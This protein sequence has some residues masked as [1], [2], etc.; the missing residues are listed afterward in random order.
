MSPV[1][2][3][4][5]DDPEVLVRRIEESWELGLLVGLAT[6]Q[7]RGALEAALGD[8][9]TRDGLSRW[10]PGVVV[11]SGG[12]TGGR[13]WC[14]QPLP[15][16]QSSAD[17]TG[18]WLEDLG[19]DPANC[20]HLDPLPLHHV[21][22]LLPMVRARR[23]GA[24][25]RCLA[26]SLMRQPTELSQ[27]CPLPDDRPVL[28]SLVPTQLQRLMASPEGL[29][30][31]AG[32]AV[33]WVGGAALP[34]QVAAAARRSGLALS[35]CYGST[36]TAAMVC[37]MPPR[38]FLAGEEG[39]GDPLPDV[40][41]RIDGPTEAV[42]V[43]TQRLSPGQLQA[44]ELLLL[45]R[46]AGGWWRSGDAGCLGPGG[47][48]VRGRLDG[49]IHSGGETVFPEELEGRLRR[50]AWSRGLPL[51]DLLLLTQDDP[52]WGERMVALVRSEATENEGKLLESLHAIVAHWPAA[53]RPRSWRLCSFL[54]PNPSGKW[55]RARWRAWLR[56][57]Q[58]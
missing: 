53:E 27:A 2:C 22:G 5:G 56:A 41:L 50:E 14:L 4:N 38:R 25:L 46:L 9:S 57:N 18:R 49:A 10:G 1:V 44:G 43:L 33:I 40:E 55:E 16:L 51:A 15:H 3:L 12:S 39:C 54:A 30:W 42:E 29:A 8:D 31:L 36:E 45:A 6:P 37:A 21:S 52:E 26:P 32:C 58:E 17:A 24:E 19:L 47:L 20:L 11:G 23:W 48:E 28:L 35:P 34:P 13:Q 7:E